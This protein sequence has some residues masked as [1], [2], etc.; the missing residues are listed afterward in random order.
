MSWVKPENRP[1]TFWRQRAASIGEMIDQGWVVWSVCVSCHLT[2]LVDLTVMEFKLG[3]AET[4]WNRQPR[5]RRFGCHGVVNFHGVPPETNQVM[6]L[7]A[8]WPADWHR[9]Q[10]PRPPRRPPEARTQ[11]SRAPPLPIGAQRRPHGP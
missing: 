9:A 11:P 4:L 3:A 8:D 7:Q 2:M 5:C 6:Q 1:A 10:P